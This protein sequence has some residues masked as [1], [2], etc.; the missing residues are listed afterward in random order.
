[1]VNRVPK[2][3][4]PVQTIRVTCRVSSLTLAPQ[5]LG[6]PQGWTYNAAGCLPPTPLPTDVGR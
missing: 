4:F 5:M 6:T 3:V 2:R 1:M